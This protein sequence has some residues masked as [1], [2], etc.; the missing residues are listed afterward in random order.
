MQEWLNN[1]MLHLPSILKWTLSKHDNTN[2]INIYTAVF[3]ITRSL[4]HNAMRGIIEEH[5]QE[6]LNL[7]EC[8][9]M[10]HTIN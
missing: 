10:A 5:I 2:S 4:F 8:T 9:N 1:G 3:E 7:D 6:D